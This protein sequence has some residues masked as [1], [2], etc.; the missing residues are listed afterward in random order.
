[1]AKKIIKLTLFLSIIIISTIFYKFFI[2]E[3]EITNVQVDVT[4]EQT[5]ENTDNNIIKNLRYEIKLD[6]QSKYIIT[7]ELSEITDISGSEIVR[8]KKAI[9]IFLDK[10]NIPLKVTSDE[11]KYNNNNHNTSF[12][13]NV[14]VEYLNNIIYSDKMD[15]DFVNN[16]VK[17]YQNVEYKGPQGNINTDNIK[18]DL[19]TKEIEI[20]MNNSNDNI[21]VVTK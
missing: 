4:D 11:A 7:S 17:I 6:E 9:G 18:I 3:K 2:V 20:Y 21:E 19:I 16:Q 5:I 12:S 13:Q 1:M 8:M 15:F 14:K 10:K